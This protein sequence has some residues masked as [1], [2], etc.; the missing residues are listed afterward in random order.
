MDILRLTQA[1]RDL[2]LVLPRAVTA[3][4]HDGEWNATSV[5][6]V[7]QLAEVALDE[8][9]LAGMTL[10]GSTVAPTRPTDEYDGVAEE[11]RALGVAGAHADPQPLK[12][13][14]TTQRRIGTVDYERMTFRH[15]P[16][17]PPSLDGLRLGAPATAVAHICRHPGPDRP[18][19]I[20]VHGTGQGGAVDIITS[21][22]GRY[23]RKLRYNI[24]MAIQPGQGLRKREWPPFP[25][26]DPITNVAG[27]IRAVSEVRALVR[28]LQPQ[29]TSITLAGLS[30]GSAVAALA[31]HFEPSVDAVALHVP[32][33]GLDQMIAQHQQRWGDAGRDMGRVMRS[34]AVSEMNSVVDPLA[35][36]PKASP[37]RRL[38]VGAWH[39]RMAMR[40]PAE[41]L[42]RRW[43]GRLH[44]HDG[45]H[46]GALFAPEVPRVT[47]QFL[48][49][50]QPA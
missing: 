27:M 18:W 49:E 10:T 19:L 17:L 16:M 43:Q 14:T 3:L 35:V 33:L 15:D 29:A 20:W 40:T 36:L 1:A 45:S 4:R 5:T 47:E 6:G 12:V 11:L 2:S 34:A 8:L 38:I 13:E 26:F 41:E 7:R 50:I 31:S 23:H 9:A 44:W 46:V 32:I 39:D 22:A 48:R 42:Q 24:A 37:E 28:W 30:L 21:R 25:D